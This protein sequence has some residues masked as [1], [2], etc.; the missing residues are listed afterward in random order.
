L[1]SVS[2][3][4]GTIR[5]TVTEACLRPAQA[6]ADTENNE[7]IAWQGGIDTG[8][9]R[10]RAQLFES[11]MRAQLMPERRENNKGAHEGALLGKR[12]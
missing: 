10:F 9:V 12:V 2:D 1:L 5:T 11:E 4:C 6:Q 3:T 8:T 7:D